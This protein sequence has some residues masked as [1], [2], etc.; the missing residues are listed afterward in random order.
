MHSGFG[1]VRISQTTGSLV[2]HLHPQHPTHFVTGT[3]APCTSIF[4]PVWLDT[5]L[6]GMG[7]EPSGVYDAS[8]LFWRH[9]VL[10][11]KMLLDYS[12]LIS[13]YK[14]ERDALE[15]GFV[16]DALN[17]AASPGEVRAQ[18]SAQCFTQA[19][20]AEAAW[21]ERVTAAGGNTG[22]DWLFTQAWNGYNRQAKLPELH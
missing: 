22:A 1:P 21:L 6:P 12:R 17:V 8:A 13:L 16:E 20:A 7:P 2:S 19:E 5:P 4:K 14:D 3:A 18:I 15:K 11:R 9:E 10:H